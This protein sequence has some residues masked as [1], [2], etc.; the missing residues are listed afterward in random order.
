M[1][2]PYI[3]EIQLVDYMDKGYWKAAPVAYRLNM[4]MVFRDQVQDIVGG[5][6]CFQ[7][8]HVP[9]CIRAASRLSTEPMLH[10]KC[11]CRHQGLAVKE[12]MAESLK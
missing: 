12:R 10:I 11:C 8:M 9:E 4:M 7:H 5:M 2:A 1:S 6:L 3:V